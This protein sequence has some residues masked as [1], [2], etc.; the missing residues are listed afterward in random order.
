[1]YDAGMADDDET[2]ALI[3]EIKRMLQHTPDQNKICGDQLRASLSAQQT[4]LQ[5]LRA[6]EKAHP[7]HKAADDASI[8]RIER[9]LARALL[10]YMKCMR[11]ARPMDVAPDSD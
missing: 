6:D 3:D 5:A 1:M 11:L 10:D 8:L 9:G 4:A 7:T 2:Q